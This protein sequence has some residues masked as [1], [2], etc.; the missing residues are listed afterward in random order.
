MDQ[1]IECVIPG[2]MV[3]KKEFQDSETEITRQA[4][5][6]GKKGGLQDTHH[7]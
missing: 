7:S 6:F 5:T 4:E 2:C 3:A 1:Q